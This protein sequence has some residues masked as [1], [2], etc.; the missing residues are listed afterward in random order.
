MFRQT[1]P[2]RFLLSLSKSALIFIVSS[3]W[4][5]WRLAGGGKAAPLR[6]FGNYFEAIL[7][8]NSST[9]FEQKALK[10][11]PQISVCRLLP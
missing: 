7:G 8:K 6:G 9:I 10:K 4:V 3:E 11:F 5:E 2:N 1:S